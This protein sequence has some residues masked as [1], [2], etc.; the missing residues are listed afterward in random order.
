MPDIFPELDTVEAPRLEILRDSYT[1]M[2]RR[3]E[4]YRQLAATVIFGTVAV[5]M[6]GVGSIG[7]WKD[8]VTA[9]GASFACPERVS[10]LAEWA[11]ITAIVVFVVILAV[12]M[13][14]RANRNFREVSTI[15]LKVEAIFCVFQP[16]AFIAGHTLF[17]PNWP[18]IANRES[19]QSN[20]PWDEDIIPLG[21]AML[22]ALL[23]FF[24]LFAFYILATLWRSNTLSVDGACLGQI[25]M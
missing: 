10:F 22:Y 3:L 21:S 25:F 5:F 11:L 4:H 8:A 13:V 6:L 20:Q 17:P 15:I 9:K 18:H 14:L 12:A 19:V 1:S 23:V 16:N 7:R 2:N 24:V